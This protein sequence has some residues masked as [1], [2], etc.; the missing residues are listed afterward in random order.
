VISKWAN[1]VITGVRYDRSVYSHGT[2]VASVEVRMDL[3]GRLGFPEVWSRPHILEAIRMDHE[4]FETA[5]PAGRDSWQRGAH[6]QI[7]R[8]HGMDYLRVN[9]AE[10]ACDDLGRTVDF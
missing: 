8:V 6:L 7:V 1:Y 9:R 2:K 5:L 10:V 4:T 3:G